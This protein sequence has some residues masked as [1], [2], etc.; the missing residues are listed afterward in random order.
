MNKSLFVIAFFTILL[1][2]NAFAR[3]IHLSITNSTK[4]TITQSCTAAS[5]GQ[6]YGSATIGAGKTFSVNAGALSD[7]CTGSPHV[8]P[9]AAIL[10]DIQSKGKEIGKFQVH[11]TYGSNNYWV[12]AYSSSGVVINSATS[13]IGIICKEGQSISSS[14]SA[15]INITSKINSQSNNCVG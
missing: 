12:S 13:N 11:Q 3:D 15:T 8:C 2:S 6:C 1:S 5:H 4:D 14:G 7:S 9:Q 10:I